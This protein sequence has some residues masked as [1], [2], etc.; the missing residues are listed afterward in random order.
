MFALDNLEVVIHVQ[1][2][3]LGG[4][5]GPG[6]D[7]RSSLESF[8]RYNDDTHVRIIMLKKSSQS[9]NQLRGRIVW[10]S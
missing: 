4:V 2:G 3:L 6:H 8:H 1:L 5:A 9:K 10:R 7:S